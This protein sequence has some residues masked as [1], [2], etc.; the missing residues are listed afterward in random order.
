MYVRVCVCVLSFLAPNCVIMAIVPLTMMHLT[1]RLGFS[2][3]LSLERLSCLPSPFRFHFSR[4]ITF[5]LS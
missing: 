1:L 5:P 3:P 4:P 2:L